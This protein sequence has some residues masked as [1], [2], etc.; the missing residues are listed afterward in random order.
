METISEYVGRTFK[1]LTETEQK[2]LSFKVISRCTHY[3]EFYDALLHLID[4]YDSPFDETGGIRVLK[5][6]FRG[7]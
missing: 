1:E 2:D 7:E 6:E 3:T 5:A 4:A